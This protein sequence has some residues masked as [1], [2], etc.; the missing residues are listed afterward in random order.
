LC[1]LR[2]SGEGQ[3]CL[4]GLLPIVE[5]RRRGRSDPETSS[6]RIRKAALEPQAGPERQ[7]A[8][9]SRPQETSLRLCEPLRD[10]FVE[11]V[12]HLPRGLLRKLS[13][14]PPELTLLPAKLALL[15]SQLTL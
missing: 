9:R 8:F 15:S 7:A 14:L 2:R 10:R 6:S 12:L 13:L 3:S 1:G 5:R 4:W 11:K